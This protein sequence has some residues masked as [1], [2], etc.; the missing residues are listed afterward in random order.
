MTQYVDNKKA[1]KVSGKMLNEI[2]I[3][4]QILTYY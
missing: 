4:F 3:I 2:G 1:A